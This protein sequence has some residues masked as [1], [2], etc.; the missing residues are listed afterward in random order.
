MQTIKGLDL[1]FTVGCELVSQ[2]HLPPKSIIVLYYHE[3]AAED[4]REGGAECTPPRW[5]TC[6]CG[7]TRDPTLMLTQLP[8]TLH[9]TTLC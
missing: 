3:E 9:T 5:G 1:H 7:A 6:G 8:A 2:L 4:T